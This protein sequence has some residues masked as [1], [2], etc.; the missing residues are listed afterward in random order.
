M[1]EILSSR[2][3]WTACSV[4]E[5]HSFSVV[6][7][8]FLPGSSG[9]IAFRRRHNIHALATLCESVWKTFSRVYPFYWAVA[10]VILLAY[11]LFL[12]VDSAAERTSALVVVGSFTLLM[13]GGVDG[14]F[15]VTQTLVHESGFHCVFAVLIPSR[16]LRPVRPILRGG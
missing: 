16:R 14:H 15:A 6:E 3:G 8:H 1:P 2:G 13:F 4:G 11:I 7:D 5:L 9:F 10:G 12:S